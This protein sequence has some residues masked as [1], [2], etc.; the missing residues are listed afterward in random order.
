MVRDGASVTPF[1][2]GQWIGVITGR[3][4][5]RICSYVSTRLGDGGDC[6]AYH[7]RPR[8]QL[9]APRTERFLIDGSAGLA[10]V[11]GTDDRAAGAGDRLTREVDVLRG[12]AHAEV[13][14]TAG[15]LAGV[16]FRFAEPFRPEGTVRA[17]RGARD[18]GPIQVI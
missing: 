16:Q 2:V 18:D 11:T 13:A 4:G 8:G 12:D 3:P 15:E 14:G 5:A 7:K 1:L 17:A 10:P 9:G 6:C